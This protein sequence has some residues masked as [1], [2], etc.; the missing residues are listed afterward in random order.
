[1]ATIRRAMRRRHHTEVTIG[2]GTIEDSRSAAQLRDFTVS[3]LVD[4]KKALNY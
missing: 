3:I 1:M 2:S 4:S